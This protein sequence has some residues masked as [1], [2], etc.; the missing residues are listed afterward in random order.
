L[1][2]AFTHALKDLVESGLSD[3]A[4]D[5]VVIETAQRFERSNTGPFDHI[6]VD[7]LQDLTVQQIRQ[8]L[9]KGKHGIAAGDPDQEFGKVK[10]D[11]IAQ[12]FR[13]VS[14]MEGS[15]NARV[16]DFLLGIGA[17]PRTCTVASS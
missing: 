14:E 4:R 3:V 16:V 7:E 8:I 13:L 6:L 17:G 10:P 11:E 12:D 9:E 5:R 1:L 15:D 2:H